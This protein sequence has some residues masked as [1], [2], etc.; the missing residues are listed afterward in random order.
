MTEIKKE[1]QELSINILEND[2]DNNSK[3]S[4]ILRQEEKWS[5]KNE[6]FFLEIK[7]DCLARSDIHN[8]I[9]HKNKKY[10]MLSSLPATIIPLALVNIDIFSSQREVQIIGLTLVSII[11]GVNTLYNFSKK[12]EVHNT[13]AGK[14]A[15]LA[16][17]VDKILIRKK[18]FRQPFDVLLEKI[19]TKKRRLDDTAP[20]V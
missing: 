11:N 7:N 3:T 19:S 2:E 12:C 9:S 18:Q 15:D 6:N 1:F 17:E 8:T 4:D 16:S 5:S 20:Y 13:F 14:Y 10:Y